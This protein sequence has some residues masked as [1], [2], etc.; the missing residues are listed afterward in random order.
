MKKIL[1]HL[2]CGTCSIIP[3][4]SLQNAGYSI[5]GYFANPNIHPLS[6]YLRRREATQQATKKMNIPVIW[7][8]QTYN[9]QKW[10]DTVH[11]K[12]IA[13]NQNHLR[14]LYCYE[15]RLMLTQKAALQHGFEFF[16]TSL[17]Y[18]K[19]QQHEL[20][21]TVGKSIEQPSLTF[22][23]QDFR[24]KWEEGMRTSKEWNLF[25]QNYC[26]CIFSESERFQ[27]KLKTLSS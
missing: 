7:D 18:S 1:I 8:D 25:R 13:N 16:T 27:K 2:C 24:D 4:Q 5:V 23:Y 26:G 21:I 12:N 14:C 10:L 9:V 3:I 11:T 15:Q 17:L 22:F 20:I 6:E 19:R